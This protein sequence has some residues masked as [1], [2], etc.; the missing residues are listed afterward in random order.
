M[1]KLETKLSLKV[2]TTPINVGDFTSIFKMLLF[3]DIM[4]H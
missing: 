4:E 1:P 3:A 2:P